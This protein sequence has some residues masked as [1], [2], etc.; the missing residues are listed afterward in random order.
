MCFN[1]DVVINGHGNEVVQVQNTVNRVAGYRA[2]L[3]KSQKD[4]AE[5]LSITPQSYS[6]KERGFRNFNDEEKI[7]L[8]ELYKMIDPD[9]TIDTI[10]F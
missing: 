3:N 5:Y 6:N 7:K 4:M 2:M 8:K 1:I 10:F 9:L